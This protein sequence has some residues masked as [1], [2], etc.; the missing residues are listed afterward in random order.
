ML[1]M[2]KPH[3]RGRVIVALAISVL[4]FNALRV[5]AYRWLLGYQFGVDCQV[6]L[7]TIIACDRFRCGDRFVIGRNNRFLGPMTFVA[8]DEVIIGRGNQFVCGSSAASA[9]KAHMK[10]ARNVM[11]GSKVLIND[12][13]Y[14]DS[15]GAIVVGEDTWIATDPAGILG[16]ADVTDI[17]GA[18]FYAPVIA[19][20]LGTGGGW[21][22]DIADEQG[23]LAGGA[24]HSSGSG[25]GEDVACDA[26]CGVDMAHPFGAGQVVTEREHFD[27][28][29]F[30]T[31]T[32]LLIDGE[33][34]IQ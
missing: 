24:P 17:V 34:A 15:Y 5:R 32:A 8:G 10:Y 3:A 9:E 29:G 12:G 4:P 20:S 14:F 22:N 25:P 7:V 23:A 27:Q 31:A 6:G 19:D 13:H 11:L 18:V 2:L 21:Q 28:T 26:D 30:V 16:E 1:G 33:V